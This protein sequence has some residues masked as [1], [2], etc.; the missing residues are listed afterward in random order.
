MIRDAS[1]PGAPRVVGLRSAQ[2]G[3]IPACLPPHICRPVAMSSDN[4]VIQLRKVKQKRAEGQVLCSSG[5][6]KWQNLKAARFDV[7]QGKLVT[8]QR[9]SRCGAEQVKLT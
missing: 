5:F 8:P 4:K 9:C 1:A 7:K 6:H 2:V 3:W